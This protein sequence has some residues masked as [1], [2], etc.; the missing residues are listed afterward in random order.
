MKFNTGRECHH[1]FEIVSRWFEIRYSFVQTWPSHV[2]VLLSRDDRSSIQFPRSETQNTLPSKSLKLALQYLGYPLL[3]LCDYCVHSYRKFQIELVD[4]KVRHA[5]S[6]SNT[7]NKTLKN[8]LELEKK[9]II[10]IKII[11]NN[12]VTFHCTNAM[13]CFQRIVL[14]ILF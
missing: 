7:L 4:E 9:H 10:V 5:S 12:K 6:E 11:Q 1:K 13:F 8:K 3:K 14:S 2:C